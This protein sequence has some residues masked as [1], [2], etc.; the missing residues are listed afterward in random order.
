SAAPAGG[1][2]RL[3]A[4]QLSIPSRLSYAPMVRVVRLFVCALTGLLS[5][6]KLSATLMTPLPVEELTQRADLILHATVTS[7]ICERTAEGRIITRVEL[8]VSEIW[9]GN[10]TTNHFTVVHGGGTV[11]NRRD[12]VS[13]QVEYTVGEE[14]VAFLVI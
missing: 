9:K 12:E 3:P 4:F 10:L 6:A 1:K 11:G 2:S 8:D 7:K 14:I 13:G 5:V